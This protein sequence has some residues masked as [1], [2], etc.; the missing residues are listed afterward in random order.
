M[1]VRVETNTPD[2]RPWESPQKEDTL[3]KWKWV[4]EAVMEFQIFSKFI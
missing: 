2:R 4:L 1:A 3:G